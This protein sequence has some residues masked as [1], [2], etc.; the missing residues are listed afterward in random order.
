MYR[1]ILYLF[2]LFSASN[3]TAQVS[4]GLK[5][6]VSRIISQPKPLVL[7][8][9]NQN[10]DYTISLQSPGIGW[11]GGA[12][13]QIKAGHFFLQPE[14]LYSFHVSKYDFTNHSSPGDPVLFK[15]STQQMDFILLTGF[16]ASVLRIGIG[17]V[18]HMDLNSQPAF[19]DIR[20]L[21]ESIEKF[22][23]GLQTGIGLDLWKVHI[24]LR[25]EVNFDNLG[26]HFRYKGKQVDFGVKES[27]VFASLGFSF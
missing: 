10:P 19:L 12:F 22:R 4:L 16:T 11:N 6:G 9:E 5:G 2:L 15:E 17:P 3:L 8:S 20:D 23:W 7:Y 21:S 1:N 26:S 25:Y 18:L 27:T 24:G 13:L 14:A